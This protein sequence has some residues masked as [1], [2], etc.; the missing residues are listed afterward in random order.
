[1]CSFEIKFDLKHL[2]KQHL[3]QLKR[4]HFEKK[5]D[6]NG[7]LSSRLIFIFI[8]KFDHFLPKLLHN[9]ALLWNIGTYEKA[10]KM[11]CQLFH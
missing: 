8:K 11:A 3:R 10:V 1:M 6:Q 2:T 4:I 9:R 7:F 5:N